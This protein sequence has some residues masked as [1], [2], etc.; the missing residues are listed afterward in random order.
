MKARQRQ[1]K[2]VGEE[3]KS[4][5][6]RRSGRRGEGAYTERPFLAILGG[7]K[8]SDKIQLI[9][10][11]LDKVNKIIICG[12][13][14]FTF[15]KTIDGVKIGSSLFDQEGSTKAQALLDKAKKNGVEVVLPVDY[16][17]ADKF[18][19]DAQGGRRRGQGRHP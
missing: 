9:E 4:K 19:K 3:Q 16:V 18:D 13:M 8:V 17:T 5:R 15:K 2:G 12:G 1:E 14:A 6:K 10:K 11:M 7:A